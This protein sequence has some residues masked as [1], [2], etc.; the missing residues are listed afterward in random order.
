MCQ[1]RCHGPG[2]PALVPGTRASKRSMKNA[3]SSR[4]TIPCDIQRCRRLSVFLCPMPRFH[5]DAKSCSPRMIKI[6]FSDPRKVKDK[7]PQQIWNS[8]GVDARYFSVSKYS[9]DLLEA[10]HVPLD[11]GQTIDASNSTWWRC[12]IQA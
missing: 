2:T 6:G 1:V 12:S 4:S 9:R 8:L 7:S 11:L 3:F 5:L 10:E